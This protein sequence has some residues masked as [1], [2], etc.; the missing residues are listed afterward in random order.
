MA[1]NKTGF[2]YYNVDTDRYM[3]IRIKRLKKDHGCDGIAVYDYILCEI[4]RNKGCFL[5]WDETTAFDVADYFG[6]KETK[7]S[8]IV[9]YCSDVGLFNKELLLRG[10]LTSASIQRRYL[11]MCVRAK[12]K[13]AYIPEEYRIIPEQ[14]PKI[15]EECA[16]TPKVCRKVKYSKVNKENSSPD[17]DEQKKEI[18]P[19]SP[20]SGTGIIPGREYPVEELARYAYGEKIWVQAMMINHRIRSEDDLKKRLQ[21]FIP[22]CI[23]RDEAKKTLRDFK[24]HFDSY[25][26]KKQ[27]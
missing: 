26:R 24:Q 17:G 20:S 27:S 22:H 4:Y 25:L 8:E 21:E 13:S 23:S 18:P 7:V 16:G 14:S 5:V 2:N 10:V 1:N 6:L 9:R 3:D 15:Q 12:R 11:E 19:S